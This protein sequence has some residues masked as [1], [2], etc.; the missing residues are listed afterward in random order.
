VVCGSS[1]RPQLE[2]YKLLY[3]Y[4]WIEGLV[5]A[6]EGGL[7]MSWFGFGLSKWVLDEKRGI[8]DEN[9]STT[10]ETQSPSVSRGCWARRSTPSVI[11]FRGAVRWSFNVPIVAEVDG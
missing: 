11:V 4:R 6:A 7:F 8:G 10:W 1:S 3:R 5:G 9:T 2:A